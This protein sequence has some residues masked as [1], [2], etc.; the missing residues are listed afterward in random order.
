MF[1]YELVTF[2]TEKDVKHLIK[3]KKLKP[4]YHV[5][6]VLSKPVYVFVAFIDPDNAEH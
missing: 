5:P 6:T 4:L 2:Q 3:E 1:K